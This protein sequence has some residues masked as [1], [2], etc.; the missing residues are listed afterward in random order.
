MRV[1]LKISLF[2]FITLIMLL[3]SGTSDIHD[4][5]RNIYY[6]EKD[7]LA[8]GIK[9]PGGIY[10]RQGR[11]SG[12][13]YDLLKRFSTRERCYINISPSRDSSSW[14]RLINGE[15][16]ILVVD[17]ENDSIPD[18]FQAD[19]ISSI[20]LNDYKHVWVVKKSDY[21]LLEQLNHWFSTFRQS[22]DYASLVSYYNVR[23]N[24]I[25]GLTVRNMMLSPYD[26]LIRQYAKSIDWD[27]RL[28]ASLIY[29]ESKF[30]MEA[31]SGKGAHG[32]MQIKPATARQFNIENIYD[33]EQ[34][35]KA[36]TLMIR[37][38]SRMYS[39]LELDSLNSVKFVLAAYN[40]GEGRVEDIRKYAMHKGAD[41]NDWESIRG[42]LP[43]M[44]KIENIPAGLL[45]LGVFNGKETMRFVDEILERYENY[46]QFLSR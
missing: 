10:L 22:K 44:R 11:T 25:S 9:V 13:H 27:W 33:P 19:V 26:N 41:P 1:S 31:K 6:L 5:D 7:S 39:G 14:N 30:S 3:I 38:L 36:G 28:L 24:H 43:S 21:I 17:S 32:L 37:R 34:N 20:D 4:P 40:A 42:V 8:A 35:I 12:F 29:Q 18:I 16:D 46:R 45:R 2:I 23:N 15:L